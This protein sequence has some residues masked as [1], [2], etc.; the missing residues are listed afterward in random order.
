MDHLIVLRTFI[1]ATAEVWYQSGEY[2]SPHCFATVFVDTVLK[3]STVQV[4]K[5]KAVL[6]LKYCGSESANQVPERYGL[7][8]HVCV[9]TYG[10]R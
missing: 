3:L 10:D 7:W 5:L 8:H 6:A 9:Y 2:W 4:H 1:E